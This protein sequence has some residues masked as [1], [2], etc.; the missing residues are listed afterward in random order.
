M[1]T[2]KQLIDQRAAADQNFA[3]L[4]ASQKYPEIAAALNE[5]PQV[6]NPTPR[7]TITLQVTLPMVIAKATQAEIDACYASEINYAVLQ[8]VKAAIDSGNQ[9]YMATMLGV[10]VR[11]GLIGAE[12]VA[13]MQALIGGTD[14]ELQFPDSSWSA[15]IAGDSLA[16][17]A[18]L[19]VVTS[20]Q[21]QAV[22]N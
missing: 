2:L 22:L 6:P 3:A 1:T 15:T 5:Q 13:K 19:G 20:A 7:G 16:M 12:T 17:A 10:A 21:V 9:A 8:D 11:K 4:V 18:G 14:P